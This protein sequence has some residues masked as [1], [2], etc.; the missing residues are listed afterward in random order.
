MALASSGAR[1][2]A[3]G[4]K[5]ERSALGLS[6]APFMISS[7]LAVVAAAAAACTAFLPDVLRGPQVMNGS[8]RGTAL[9]VL[10]AA[11]PILLLAMF[12]V[13]R[14]SVRATVVW[15]GAIAYL[16]YNA[17]LFLF[18]TP[19]NSLFLL[20]TSMFAL[21]V[22]SA[23]TLVT[24]MEVDHF[25]GHLPARA[26]A[27]FLGAVA[28]L[29]AVAWLS[30]IVPALLSSESPAF[31]AG[32]GLTTN[33]IYVQDLAFWIPLTLVAAVS[34]WRRKAWGYVLAGAMLVYLVLES[35]SIAVDQWFG[36]AADPSSTLASATLVPAFAVVAV[37]GLIPVFF[38]FRGIE[39]R[40]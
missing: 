11:I 27:G 6:R 13:G 17:V 31:L 32:T 39:R 7:A 23:A 3:L 35:I 26:I 34:L 22:W 15:L 30:A 16:L 9:V 40:Q 36:H 33:A 21:A 2:T 12:E 38:Y 19:F 37:I 5:G 14:G 8:A 25:G 29:N 4:Q 24:R 10:C 1:S 28:V 20:Y 18:E